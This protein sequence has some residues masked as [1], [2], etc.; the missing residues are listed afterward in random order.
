[1]PYAFDTYSGNGSLTDFNISFP[2]INEDHVKVYVNY[3][4]TSFT[5]EPNKST[6]RLASAPASGAVVE[7][8][9][10]TPLANVL[11]D[12]ADGSTLT[13][14]D[15]DTNN[16]QHL[17]IEQE[18]DDIQNKAIALSP[19]TGLATANN[20]RITEVADPTAAQDAVTKAYLERSGSIASAQIADGTIVN[21]DIA[22]TTITGGKLVNDT[23]TAT[24]IAANAVTASELAND[25]V[26]TD[27]IVNLNVT[28]GKIAN[29][30]VDGTKI[31][32]DSV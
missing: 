3:T 7:V 1:M 13:A 15:L 21:G 2:Y 11:V 20:R 18:L 19:T 25:A 26:D 14:G 27:A 17:Y 32:D 28:R 9:R 5:F 30:A 16:L 29:D 6:A 31:A 10:I 22:N 24:Q 8:R 23:I 4:Q 12:Y